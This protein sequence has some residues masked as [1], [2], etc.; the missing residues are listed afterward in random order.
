MGREVR[1]VPVDWQHPKD[2]DGNFIPTHK[3]F[4][5]DQDEIEQG[6]R[7]GWLNDDKENYGI[8]VMPEWPHEQRTHFQ[9]YETCSEGTPI[10]P[11]M[12]TP[13]NLARWLTD[14]KASAFADET[15]TYDE[16]LS[17]IRSTFSVSAVIEKGKLISGVAFEH[18][19]SQ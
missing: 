9:M 16:W 3:R 1:K 11:V 18:R 6:L 17:I 7:D 8:V 14:N 5:Y 13:E 4:P 19:N 10:S 2:A 12:D 15:A